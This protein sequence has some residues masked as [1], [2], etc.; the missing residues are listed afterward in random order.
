MNS[1][2][3]RDLFRRELEIDNEITVECKLF[4]LIEILKKEFDIDAKSDEFL[5]TI[6]KRRIVDGRKKKSYITFNLTIKPS[7]QLLQ[8][9]EENYPEMII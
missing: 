2:R 8:K 5:I 6:N 9:F 7:Q 4:E 1:F 3:V